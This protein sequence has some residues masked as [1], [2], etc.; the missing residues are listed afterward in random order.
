MNSFVPHRIFQQ[1]VFSFL[2]ARRWGRKDFNQLMIQKVA[3]FILNLFLLNSAEKGAVHLIVSNYNL[4]CANMWVGQWC[5]AQWTE[6]C[7]QPSSSL[8]VAS[9]VRDHMHHHLISTK[10]CSSRPQ[11]HPRDSSPHS[12]MIV[13]SEP[14][15]LVGSLAAKAW[16]KRKAKMVKQRVKI[17]GFYLKHLTISFLALSSP[18][19][20]RHIYLLTQLTQV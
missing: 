19:K 9:F 15:G 10:R 7:T 6:P 18:H 1:E 5:T 12:A 17:S 20:S 11:R 4:T 8:C 3:V 14:G 2:T 16:F 13:T